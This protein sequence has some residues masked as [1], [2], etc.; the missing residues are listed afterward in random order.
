VP[1]FVCVL[2]LVWT[3]LLGDADLAW[4]V[5]LFC[6]GGGVGLFT[7]AGVAGL[8]AAFAVAPGVAVDAGVG[9][10]TDG[11]AD[12]E[13]ARCDSKRSNNPPVPLAPAALPCTAAREVTGC[14]SEKIEGKRPGEDGAVAGRTGAPPERAAAAVAAAAAPAEM[15]AGLA[16]NAGSLAVSGDAT[17]PCES[18]GVPS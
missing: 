14:S 4:V 16:S 12:N 10:D 17:G 15:A 7:F 5:V 11:V 9:S 2:G 8:G 1:G 3:A 6:F 18:G 13:L